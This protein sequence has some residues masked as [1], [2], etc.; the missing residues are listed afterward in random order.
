VGGSREGGSW[1]LQIERVSQEIGRS[2]E[3]TN[4]LFNL[5]S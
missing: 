2:G 5:L 3:M 4:D 1:S